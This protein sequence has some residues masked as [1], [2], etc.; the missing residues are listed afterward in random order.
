MKNCLLLLALPLV[1]SAGRDEW[2]FANDST[3]TVEVSIW[4]SGGDYSQ[5]NI[6][7][8]GQKVT[9][10]APPD[11]ASYSV[12]ADNRTLQIDG[13]WLNNP[14]PGLPDRRGQHRVWHLSNAG[15]G[16]AIN[17]RELYPTE[18]DDSTESANYVVIFVMGMTFAASIRFVRIGLRWSRVLLADQDGG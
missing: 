12:Y 14:D 8:P 1:L 10:K 16:T 17:F 3:Y 5:G 15:S 13:I 4:E 7:Q 11:G 6:V 18:A 2:T 9:I